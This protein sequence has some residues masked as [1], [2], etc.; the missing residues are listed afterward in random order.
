MTRTRW[1]QTVLLSLFA[2][3]DTPNT[4]AIDAQRVKES[5]KPPVAIR[6]ATAKGEAKPPPR[7]KQPLFDPPLVKALCEGLKIERT[8][9]HDHVVLNGGPV[10]KGE[11]R[12]AE[13]RL[14]THDADRTFPLGDVA[15]IQGGAGMGRKARVYLRDGTVAGGVL[16]W[17]EASF[18]DA[19]LG[20]LKLTPESLDTLIL[21]TNDKDHQ[22]AKFAALW[23]SQN[24]DVHG[25]PAVLPGAVHLRW[26][27]GGMDV[28][29]NQIASLRP[30]PLPEMGQ[31]ILLTD[32]SRIHAWF[33][34]P[35]AN[36]SL[37]SCVAYAT[38][39]SDLMSV[40]GRQE[41]PPAATDISRLQTTDASLFTGTWGQKHI[42]LATNTSAIQV[43]VAEIQRVRVEVSPDDGSPLLEIATISGS[44]L[45]GSA[46]TD[47]LTWKRGDQLLKVPWLLISEI[48]TPKPLPAKP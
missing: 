21:R 5:A 34:T 19:S 48:A 40:L 3:F 42:V 16:T 15:A 1:F 31:E 45:R 13:L 39:W 26:A 9:E 38:T 12:A 11:F 33:S 6:A 46:V 27:G 37:T 22:S 44:A 4:R 36:S 8:P 32:G 23:V 25:I 30:L 7:P 24:G 18:K 14:K 2:C 43:P 29:W 10:L 41:L 20:T 35:A 17:K 28:P 47:A